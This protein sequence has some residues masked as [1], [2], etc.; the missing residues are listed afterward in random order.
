MA[1]SQEQLV[2]ILLGALTPKELEG[3]AV[4][5]ADQPVA[6]GATLRFARTT[7]T[8]P[9]EAF[10]GF[11]DRDPLA[12]WGHSSRYVIISR[13]TGETQSIEAQTPPFGEEGVIW[14]V[15]YKAASVPEA[16]LV[17]PHR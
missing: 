5:A 3:A 12:N 1:L 7:I 14:R 2:A 11:V 4:Y 15:V 10:L 8:A 16:I 9:W 6:A 17:Q 13:Q